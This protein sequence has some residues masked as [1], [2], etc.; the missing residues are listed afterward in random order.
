MNDDTISRQAA[1]DALS[2]PH[3][4]L[5]PIRT[6]EALPSA[7]R[8]GRWIPITDGLPEERGTYLVTVN[9]GGIRVAIAQW[10]YDVDNGGEWY[11]VYDDYYVEDIVAWMPLPE[12]Y[13]GGEEK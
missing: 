9:D 11:F 4:I 6:L 10:W 8:R 12:P 13:K 2:T 3:G 5:Y 1:I 7:E